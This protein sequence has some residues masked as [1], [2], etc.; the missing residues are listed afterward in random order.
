[1][2]TCGVMVDVNTRR[3]AIEKQLDAVAAEVGGRVPDDEALLEEVTHLVEQPT[4]FLGS[5]EE[6]HLVLPQPVLVTVMKKHQRY[7]PIMNPTGGLLPYFA[8]VRNGGSQH[9]D[10]VR[11]GNENVLRAR[12]A[13]A[14]FFFK[15][16]TAHKLE[17]F[18]PRLDT[19]TFQE[20]LGSMLDKSK[21]LETLACQLG[22][23]LGLTAAELQIVAR[24]AH[25]CKADLATNMVVE[26]TS[27]Q[28]VMGY[29]YARISGEPEPVAAAIVEHYY[30]HAPLPDSVLS[31]PG[32]ALNLANRLDSLCGLFAVGKAPTGSADPFALRRD[33]LSIVTILLEGQSD[34]D[35]LEGL[36]LA[37]GLLPVKVTPESLAETAEFVQRRLEGVLREEYDLPHDVVQ[38]VLV[39]RGNNPYLALQAA[40]DLAVAV[41]RHDWEDTLNAYARCVR[42]VRNID[43]RFTTQPDR[44]EE[45]VESELHGAYEQ[46]LGRL[47]ANVSMAAVIET[48]REMMVEP[49][50]AFFDGVLVM[51]DDETV[52]QNRLALLQDIR[53]LTKGYA[54]FSRLQGF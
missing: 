32:L 31:R 6:K 50:N 12:Y 53:D 45:P 48:L 1:M 21:R 33:A 42:I 47:K 14:E 8:G 22:E 19:L 49:I 51:T 52:K 16:D 9:L 54:D 4:A 37:A 7:F 5:F 44:F 28:G 41:A 26:F 24:A 29:E 34:F 27:L 3:A 17:S 15:A 39:E 38:A 25:L 23:R 13:D 20:Q 30:P 36:R 2:D 18:L 10:I 46:A 35:V 43:Q 11:R 40:Q